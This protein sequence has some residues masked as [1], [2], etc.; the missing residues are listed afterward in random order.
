MHEVEP[1]VLS[2][3]TAPGVVLE[4]LDWGGEGDPVI[5]LAGGGN[6]AHTF[7]EF[8]P[9]L[10][11]DFRVY[12]ITRRGIGASSGASPRTMDDHVD[13]IVAV[14]DALQLPTVVLVGHSFAGMEMARF[15]E[16][17]GERCAGLVYLD[18]AYDHRNPESL[19]ALY[20]RTPP[21]VPPELTPA[22]S[23]S[24][25]A[26]R[27]Y[28]LRTQGFSLPLSEIRNRL[29]FDDSGRFVGRLPH[30]A[31]D[32]EETV[33]QWEAIDCP[34]LAMYPVMAPLETWLPHFASRFDSLSQEDLDKADA[35]ERAFSAWSEERQAS[36]RGLPRNQVIEFP[37]GGH[38]FFLTKPEE[39]I[40]ALREFVL[41]L[42]GDPVTGPG[43]T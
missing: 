18:A 5:L 1:G 7:D 32:V 11:S 6:T 21:P 35:Y 31:M 24:I 20:E 26:I 23:A 4:V 19:V 40:A 42:P 14:L 43:A 9:L 12:G 28:N 2:V 33:P 16:A 39:T 34:S 41:G 15:G 22:D 37:G 27:A 17:Y 10:S 25:D 38:Y 8:A 3:E 30:T 36:F 13:D 29:R